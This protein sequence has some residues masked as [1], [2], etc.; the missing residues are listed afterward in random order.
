MRVSGLVC[1]SFVVA[2]AVSAAACGRP[3]SAAATKDA[4]PLAIAVATVESHDLRRSID[5]TGTL[6]ADEEVTV[7]AEVEGRVL[8]IAADL[9]DRVTAGQALVVLIR[10]LQYR[11]TSS[12]PH[13]GGPWRYGVA[14]LAGAAG[15]RT[16]PDVQRAAAELE[17]AGQVPP[18]S[19]LH[20]SPFRNRR[21]TTRTRC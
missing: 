12:A 1:G 15:H 11:S 8:R 10:K 18:A 14:D 6:A 4:A 19:E 3:T 2:S 7:S 21:W 17:Q 9:G 5:V 16:N 13:W 20:G